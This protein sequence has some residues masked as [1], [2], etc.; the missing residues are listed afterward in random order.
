VAEIF[1]R[2]ADGRST[3][4][5]ANDERMTELL[6]RSYRNTA[7]VAK[8]AITM[9]ALKIEREGSLGVGNPHSG[10]PTTEIDARAVSKTHFSN[11]NGETL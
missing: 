4:V 10:S 2:S 7:R 6:F 1:G 5:V 11:S 9:E 3:L 8:N